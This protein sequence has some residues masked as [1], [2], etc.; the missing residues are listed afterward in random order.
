MKETNITENRS[1]K[2]FLA[3]N[4]SCVEFKPN[5]LQM[6]YKFKIRDISSSGMC[7]VVNEN[8]ELLQHIKKGDIYNMKYFPEEGDPQKMKTEIRH[9]SKEKNGKYEGHILVGLSI[10][11]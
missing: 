10:L 8:S 6:S 11:D 1:E 4:L 5:L 2:R 3:A 7:I 9:I